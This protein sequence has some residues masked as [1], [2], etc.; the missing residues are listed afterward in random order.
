MSYLTFLMNKLGW[1]DG[2]MGGWMDGWMDGWKCA[3]SGKM[4]KSK[5]LF[6]R[7]GNQRT[8]WSKCQ[9]AQ[10]KHAVAVKPRVALHH[11]GN[12]LSIRILTIRRR[13][14]AQRSKRTI[15]A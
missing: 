3:F 13:R 8:A 9:S 5:Q 7:A 15:I 1:M 4:Q 10:W 2:R 11:T 14:I 12:V 6:D